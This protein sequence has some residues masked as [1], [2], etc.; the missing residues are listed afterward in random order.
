MEYMQL[1][2][3][4]FIECTSTSPKVRRNLAPRHFVGNTRKMFRRL[5]KNPDLSIDVFP[6]GCSRVWKLHKDVGA[7]VMNRDHEKKA[8]IDKEDINIMD[9]TLITHQGLLNLSSK[10]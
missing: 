8:V 6:G 7:W 9:E 10:W 3:E 1:S 5:I 4:N 2:D